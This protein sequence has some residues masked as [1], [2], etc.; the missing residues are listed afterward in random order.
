MKL[1]DLRTDYGKNTLSEGQ[2]PEQPS[3]LFSNWM[4]DALEEKVIEANAMVLSTV[5]ENGFPQ[6]RIVLLRENQQ[7]DFVF[8]SNYDSAKGKQI[9]SSGKASLLFFWPTLERQIRITGSCKKVEGHISDAYFEA[10]P[11]GSKIGAWASPQSQVISQQELEEKVQAYQKQYPQ[12][13]PRPEHW[14]GF[15]LTAIRYEFW[16]GRPSRL[17][18]R[19]VFER[20]GASDPSAW[21]RIRLAP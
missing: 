3:L 11:Y 18:D 8:Y 6:S 20:E 12:T 14:G 15:V 13:V 10:R 7:D 19:L 21:S 2:A 9:Q 17:H 4:E 1:D 5:D 16:Q